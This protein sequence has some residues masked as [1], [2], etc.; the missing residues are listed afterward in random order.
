MST[1]FS[2]SRLTWTSGQRA[3]AINHPLRKLRRVSGRPSTSDRP[4]INP[5]GTFFSY[6]FVWHAVG[7][8]A[9]CVLQRDEKHPLAATRLMPAARHDHAGQ[10]PILKNRQR[11]EEGH[12]VPLDEEE[13]G[14]DRHRSHEVHGY[15][16]SFV[17]FGIPASS[18]FCRSSSISSERS[19]LRPSSWWIALIFSLR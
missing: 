12:P 5:I 8:I 11:V 13:T 15:A 10:D 14:Q 3:R 2:R 7:G 9:Q 18:I 1:D 16:F 4:M 19:S 6:I 17:S